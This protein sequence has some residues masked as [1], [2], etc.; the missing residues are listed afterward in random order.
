MI[1]L[2][3]LLLMSMSVAPLHA[4][5]LQFK[6]STVVVTCTTDSSGQFS[7][8]QPPSILQ[9]VAVTLASDGTGTYSTT[10]TAD[11]YQ[12]VVDMN[13]TKFIAN[14][15]SITYMFD[16][17]L[18]SRQGTDA[19]TAILTSGLVQ[20]DSDAANLNEITY[21]GLMIG[22]NTTTY[23]PVLTIASQNTQNL[24]HPARRFM[25]RGRAL[26]KLAYAHKADA[27]AGN[28]GR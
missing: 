4:E 17:G 6:A 13:L 22:T 3:G 23:W 28:I 24:M 5:V 10:V 16:L 9:D 12:F 15:K 18:T 14:D 20:V 7:C 11:G 1:R 25:M 21:N 8:Q 27:V 19:N 26:N 2:M